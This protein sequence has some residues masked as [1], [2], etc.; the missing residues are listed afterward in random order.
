MVLVRE[1]RV[2]EGKDK[3][4]KVNGAEECVNS[5]CL[6]FKCG[7]T[8]K[9]IDPYSAIAIVMVRTSDLLSDNHKTMA[10]FSRYIGP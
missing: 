1:H 10:P 9:S 7:Y 6:L 3:M 4:V 2:I 5:E 8:I